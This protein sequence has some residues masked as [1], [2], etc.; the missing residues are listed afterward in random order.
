MH[1]TDSLT[2]IFEQALSKLTFSQLVIP[3]F[4]VPTQPDFGD[5]STNLAMTLFAAESHDPV[6]RQR[7]STPRAVAEAIVNA[8]TENQNALIE[9]ISIAGPGFINLKLSTS[10]LMTELQN[11]TS[12]PQKLIS[13]NPQATT[14]I[15][16]YSSPN[17]AKPF[18][19][20]HLRSTI[21]GEAVANLLEATGWQV[22]RDNHLGDWGTQFG[23]LVYAIKTWGDES[24]IENATEPVKELVKLYVKFH[25]EAE[26]KP[27]LEAEGRSWFKRLETG[28]PEAR[29]LWQKCIDWSWREFDKLYTKLG[30]H[31]TENDG[32]GYGESYFEN[33]M[34]EIIDQLENQSVV[35]YRTGEDGA[36]L[37]FFPNDELPPL[38]ILKK[39]G[40]TLYATRDLATDYFRLQQYGS[41]ITVIN[42]VGAEQAL[43][44]RQLYRLEVLLGWYQP[45]QRV[46]VKHGLYRFKDTKMSTRK[47]NVIW[48]QDVLAEAEERAMQLAQRPKT[49]TSETAEAHTQS[50]SEKELFANA[51]AIGLGALKWN[52]LKRSSHLDVVFDWDDILSMQG[53]SGPYMQ[54]TYVRCLSVLE[55]SGQNT[56]EIRDITK[57]IDLLLYILTPSEKN[58]LRLL[59]QFDET[60]QI[61]AATYQP[62]HLTTY[63][64]QLA[65]S[66][67]SFYNTEPILGAEVGTETT[68]FRLLLTE[69]VKMVLEKG[70][71]L[72]GIKTVKKM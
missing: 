42:E 66:Y 8:V 21:I 68:A 52:D 50:L 7:Y 62:H 57:H 60:V 69:A 35:E 58:I 2:A 33:K 1:V 9:D 59:L 4:S 19:I 17:I 72:L 26:T 20:G 39:D 43:Y 67:N 36:K 31:F 5:Y 32:R 45:T 38:M 51:E 27:E 63:L 44:F 24:A 61:A 16:E 28:D 55:K 23:K 10:F 70:L 71:L 46:H 40:S 29:R 37:V 3:T 34:A 47:G 25:E 54:Y 18:T 48:L 41:D 13:Q 56:H 53:N 22:K 6:F 11:M 65:Q 49:G 15:V 12:E 64:Y 30:V 14:A